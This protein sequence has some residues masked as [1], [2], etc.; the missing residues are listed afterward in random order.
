MKEEKDIAPMDFSEYHRK[1]GVS[2]DSKVYW[3][4]KYCCII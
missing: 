3:I 2:E 4:E 1:S